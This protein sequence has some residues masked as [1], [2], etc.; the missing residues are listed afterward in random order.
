MATLGKIREKSTLLLIVVG[1]AMLAFLLP[2]DGVQALFGG[3]NQNVGEI[4]GVEVT[5]IEF[6]NRIQVQIQNW[7][8]QNNKTATPE[9]RES[10]REQLWNEMVSDQ[11][12]GAQFAEL[13]LAISKEEL[14]DMIQ[15]NDPHPQVKQAF[16]NPETGEF[17]PTQVLQFLKNLE[18]MPPQN[19][20]QWLVFE[21]GIEKEQVAKKYDNLIAKGMFVTSSMV[22]NAYIEQNENRNIQFVA[23]R[24]A[25][26]MDTAISVTDAELT[27]YY[28]EH[29]NEYKQD[30]SREIEYVRFDVVP[31]EKDRAEASK[32][33]NELTEEFKTSTNDTAYVTDYSDVPVMDAY[34]S[35]AALSASFDSAFF[36]AENGTMVG[37]YEDNG[38][39]IL[40]KLSDFKMVPDSVNARHI[41][42]KVTQ[43]PSDTLLEAKIDSIKSVIEGGAN[44][45]DVAKE[46]SEDVG[47]A[48][49]GGDLGWFKEGVM[50]PSFNDACFNGKAGDLVVVQSQF[51]FHLIE[52]MEQGAPVRKVQIAKV[53]RKIEASNETYDAVFADASSFYSENNTTEAFDKATEE[54][55]TKRIADVK[56]SDKTIVGLESPRE[57]IRWAFKNEKGSVGAPFQFGSSFVV[58]HIG[59]VNDGEYSSMDKVE[60]QVKIGAKKKK[61]AVEFMAEMKGATNLEELAKKIGGTVETAENINFAS[62]A[63]QGMGQ[64][65]SLI[66]VTSKIGEGQMTA[67]P[68]EGNSAVYMVMVSKV[69]P[70]TEAKDNSA[71][72]TQLESYNKS[73]TYQVFESLK[74]KFGVIDER[75]RFY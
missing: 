27:A 51:G 54:K 35:E 12:L 36:Y 40:A 37:P 49:E 45:A 41:L 29:K 75:Y 18:N 44:F 32:W 11:I 6:N 24:Y 20:N 60:I 22:K 4:D 42:L 3:G 19:K 62:Y 46:K 58:A 26:V 39:F 59:S 9:V 47:S 30:P 14:F 74:D 71:I 55:F 28:N 21:K 64:E 65:P 8:T 2:S 34:I 23:K 5:A 10:L 33:I 17:N 68:I 50:V 31:S 15:G 73:R 13:G 61:K 52:I 7:E 53:V 72:R 67:E 66:G 56:V 69:T 38:A 48:I 43:T 25:S 63:I 57:M 70:A 1:V 16:T